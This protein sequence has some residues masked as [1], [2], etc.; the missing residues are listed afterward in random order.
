ME[1]YLVRDF[2]LDFDNFI[3]H[4]ITD[5]HYNILLINSKHYFIY[6]IDI[7][8]ERGYNFSHITEMNNKTTPDK[9]IW[10]INITLNNYSMWLKLN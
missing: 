7:F 9:K 2:K 8:N 3:P 1:L 10:V 6:W 5:F 4:I